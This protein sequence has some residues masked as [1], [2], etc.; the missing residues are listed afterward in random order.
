MP[1]I[2]HTTS[3]KPKEC[4][5][6][7][8]PFGDTKMPEPIILPT[9]RLTPCNSEISCFRRMELVEP[10][11]TALAMTQAVE[12]REAGTDRQT[13][14]GGEIEGVVPDSKIRIYGSLSVVTEANL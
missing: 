6:C 5:Y 10:V 14:R 7:S 8:T 4:V 9:I 2:A 11:S 1:P 12:D 13:D 3:E